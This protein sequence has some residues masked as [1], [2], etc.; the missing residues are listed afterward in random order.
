MQTLRGHLQ[1]H[2]QYRSCWLSNQIFM[3]HSEYVRDRRNVTCLIEEYEAADGRNA[4]WWHAE[5][6]REQVNTISVRYTLG[7]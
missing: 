5:G 1:Q 3:K 7:L 6:Q 2:L 4:D